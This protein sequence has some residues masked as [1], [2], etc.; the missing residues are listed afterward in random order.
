M[1][2]LDWLRRERAIRRNSNDYKAMWDYYARDDARDWIFTGATDDS[3]ETSGQDD[4]ARL[5]PFVSPSSKV[6]NIGC[7]IGRVEPYLAP[8]VAESWAVDISGEMIARAGQRLAGFPNVHLR[9]LR[10]GEFLSSFEDSSFDLVFSLL[11]LQHMEREDAFLYLEDARRV[12]RPGGV[13]YVQFPNFLSPE[14]TEAFLDPI[15]RQDRSPSRVRPYTEPEVRHVLSL[16][17][18]EVR[19]LRIEAGRAGNAEIYVL[20]VPSRP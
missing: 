7:G 18:F 15:R 19:E 4:A 3:F 11:V 8:R 9:E 20:A 13:L 17:G 2:I 12:L 14:Y 16:A 6:L 10:L 5:L 1:R